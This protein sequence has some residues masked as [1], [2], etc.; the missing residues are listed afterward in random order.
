MLN[1]KEPPM[2]FTED[3]NY[4]Y[5]LSSLIYRQL[6]NSNRDFS[7]MLHDKGFTLNNKS[8]KMFA[9]SRLLPEKFKREDNFIILDGRI[10]WYVSSPIEDFILYFADA[11]TSDSCISINNCILSVESVSLIRG[12]EF[13]RNMRF[14][15][16]SPVVVTE[17]RD[18]E[19]RIKPRTVPVDSPK[20][21]ENIKSNLLRKYFIL[22]N[23]LPDD[24]D[25]YIK[26][27]DMD[28]YLKG[29]LINY[30]GTYIKGYMAPF[31]FKGNTDLIKVAYETGLGEKNS[32]GMG[33]LEEVKY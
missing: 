11:I 24:M 2:S 33:F 27:S 28:K 14:K 32:Q 29:K 13:K 31:D 23:S 26:F 12:I 4:F 22:N 7:A 3:M 9:F 19:G 5:Y 1:K 8:F 10:T 15:P 30:K 21:V 16:L 25:F 6:E 20:F 17:G 18:V